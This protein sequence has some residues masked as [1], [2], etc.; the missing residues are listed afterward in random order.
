MGQAL[1]EEA[2]ADEGADLLEVC[3]DTR[4]CDGHLF[5]NPFTPAKI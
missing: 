2:E 3:G 4:G 5:L 1:L